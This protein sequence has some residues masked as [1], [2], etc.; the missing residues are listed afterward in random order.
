MGR[1]VKVLFWVLFLTNLGFVIN[2]WSAIEFKEKLQKEALVQDFQKIKHQEQ[3][4]ELKK[5]KVLSALFEINKKIKKLVFDRSR[6]KVDLLML[7]KSIRQIKDSSDE[8]ALEI[9]S[10]KKYLAQRIRTLYHVRMGSWVEHFL[11]A[12]SR[13]EID[14]Q[15]KILTRLAARDREAVASL[16]YNLER[17]QL[18]KLKLET[19][20]QELLISEKESRKKEKE[21]AQEE[22]LKSHLLQG[23][24]RTQLFAKEQLEQVRQRSRNYISDPSIVELIYKPS[25]MAQ[26]SKLAAPVSAQLT[27]G[28]GILE[29]S[30][31]QLPHRGSYYATPIGQR[32]RSVFEG[33]V[34][35]IENLPYFGKTVILDHG[36]HY[37]TT[38][39]FLQD[40]F[41]QEGEEVVKDQEIATTG[42]SEHKE[43]VGLYFELRHFSEPEDPEQWFASNNKTQ[44]E[45]H[46]K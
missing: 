45:F 10:Q 22:K 17:L 37:Y 23:A 6:L 20:K 42:V 4:A 33:R 34:R 1:D 43:L 36:D 21:F 32:V 46:E 35:K 13:G 8:L 15:L 30:T 26:K 38:Y 31:Y 5:R 3:Q 19:K 11:T 29:M 24:Q 41:V 12:K 40:V 39:A 25:F 9:S 7:E 28:Y 16:N 14:R 2:S 27:Q 44:E 18:N